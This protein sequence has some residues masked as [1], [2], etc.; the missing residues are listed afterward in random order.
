MLAGWLWRELHHHQ[1]EGEAAAESTEL[2]SDTRR[3]KWP[4]T[5]VCRSHAGSV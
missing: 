1:R 4:D 5:S 3:A 2:G